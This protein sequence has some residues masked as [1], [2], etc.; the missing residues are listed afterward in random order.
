MAILEYKAIRT[1]EGLS[2]PLW[3]EKSGYFYNPVDFTFVG[4]SKDNA[5]WYTP[6]TVFTLT[7][8]ELENRQVA[9]HN[10]NP[11]MTIQTP[12]IDS[13][14]MTEAEVRTTIQDWV[15]EHEVTV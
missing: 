15:T 2:A 9:I 14:Q 11:M 1:P 12:E 7:P 6:D 10:N 4:W 8:L 13:V 3:V 5:E